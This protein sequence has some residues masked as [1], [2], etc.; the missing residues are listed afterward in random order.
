MRLTQVVAVVTGAAGGLGAAF[1]LE[2]LREGAKVAAGDTNAAGLRSLAAAA[3]ALPGELMIGRLD[4]ADEASVESFCGLA[5]SQLG[6][7]NVL[8]NGAGI[9]R[10]GMLVSQEGERFSKLPLTQWRKVL[11]VNLTGS[12]LMSRQVVAQ[13]LS[14]GVREGVII[15]ISSIARAGNPGQSS[16]AA[17]K[18]GLDACTRTWA[19][20]LARYGI[21]VGGIA[22]GVADTPLLAGISEAALS[23]L[24]GDVPL[25]RLARPED[26]WRAVRFVIESD[27]FTGR[28]LE[29]DGGATMGKA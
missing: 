8:V 23:R 28:T 25:G 20:E 11:D 19:L 18:A 14:G 24:A 26:V 12:F 15:N 21:R 17:S 29:I 6:E 3:E 7:L 9:L 1:S 13:M 2:L 16:Y 27:F 4:V 5:A 10:D 22:P